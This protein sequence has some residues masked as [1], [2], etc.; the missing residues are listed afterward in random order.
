MMNRRSN[1]HRRFLVEPPGCTPV[2]KDGV[3]SQLRGRVW[4]VEVTSRVLQELQRIL[5]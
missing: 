5:S 3:V 4:V 1:G 2:Q